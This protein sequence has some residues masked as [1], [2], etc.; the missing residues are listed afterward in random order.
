MKA[1]L[2]IKAKLQADLPQGLF[3]DP[4]KTKFVADFKF[5]ESLYPGA[6]N[7]NLERSD[8]D[9]NPIPTPVLVLAIKDRASNKIFWAFVDMTIRPDSFTA[10]AMGDN[11]GLL[12]VNPNSLEH[13]NSNSG[14]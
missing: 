10:T 5:S 9:G 1:N 8:E 6:L 2:E 4:Y 11:S 13:L 7:P 12:E 14:S 3:I